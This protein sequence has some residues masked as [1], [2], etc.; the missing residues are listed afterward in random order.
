MGT[1]TVGLDLGDRYS[2]FCMVDAEG[3]IVEEGRVRTE[4]EAMRG[5]FRGAAAWVVLEVGTHSPWVS[6]ELEEL[7]HEVIVANPRRLR[8]IWGDSSKTDRQDA[9]QLDRVGRMDPTLLR[10]IRHRGRDTQMLMAVLRSRDA[11]VRV[12]AS[13]VAHARGSV[14]AAGYRLPKCPTPAFARRAAEH[15]PEALRPR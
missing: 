3:E 15:I 10:P 7:G 6:R 2:R 13:L 5:R 12:R 4:V 14:K 1:V 9:E 11:L 8:F